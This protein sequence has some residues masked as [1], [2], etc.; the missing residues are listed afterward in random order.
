MTQINRYYMSASNGSVVPHESDNGEWVRYTDVEKTVPEDV[1]L[2]IYLIT[3]HLQSSRSKTP[4]QHDGM[5]HRAYELYNRYDVEGR[6][7]EVT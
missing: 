2:F 1:R 5:F 6:K 7:K 4:E 3:L